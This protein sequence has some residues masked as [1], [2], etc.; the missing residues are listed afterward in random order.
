[1]PGPD[2]NSSMGWVIN[3]PMRS[4]TSGLVRVGD[5]K[6]KDEIFRTCLSDNIVFNG[7]PV[8][9]AHLIMNDP[10]QQALFL[11]YCGSLTRKQLEKERKGDE[12]ENTGKIHQ[13]APGV[14]SIT[15]IQL[16]QTNILKG[17]VKA[18][19]ILV[20]LGYSGWG[21]SQL[22][23]EIQQGTWFPAA[24][25]SEKDARSLLLSYQKEDTGPV[26]PKVASKE[27]PK[28]DKSKEAGNKGKSTT[29]KGNQGL[30]NLAETTRLNLFSP[31]SG[32]A[33]KVPIPVKMWK[34][35]LHSMG[36]NY[37]P[38]SRL[39]AVLPLRVMSP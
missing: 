25:G 7:G 2:Y 37:V 13:V 29:R 17:R 9:G 28:V 20:I 33:T 11:L 3:M 6:L 19:E 4:K 38:M 35:F 5:L 36:S 26:K 34:G 10:G 22:E 12:K 30:R 14:L 16:L 32:T 21:K 8:G 24:M 15:D 1:M 39:S 18:S 27:D 23:G 31:P